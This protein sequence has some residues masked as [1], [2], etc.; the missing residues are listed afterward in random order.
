MSNVLYM[1]VS[2]KFT[3]CDQILLCLM[4]FV[5]CVCVYVY[6][7]LSMFYLRKYTLTCCQKCVFALVNVVKC[8][9]II[10]NVVHSVISYYFQIPTPVFL[11]PSLADTPIS[12]YT[13][14]TS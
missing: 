5:V 8:G 1:Y 7:V 4:Q 12:L 13:F 9:L 10:S 11:L 3:E 6:V 14:C 2:V